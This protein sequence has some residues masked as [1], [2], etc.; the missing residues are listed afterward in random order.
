MDIQNLRLQLLHIAEGSVEEA[1]AMENY[2]LGVD[3]SE[4]VMGE[5]I[6]ASGN[7]AKPKNEECDCFFCSLRKA[8]EKSNSFS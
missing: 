6:K 3:G 4:Q 2:V 7:S 5:A 8:I 1:Q